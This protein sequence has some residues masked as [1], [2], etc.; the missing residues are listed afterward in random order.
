MNT[1]QI[2]QQEVICALATPSGVGAIAIIRVSGL[3]SIA[4][5]NS[6]FS[7]KNLENADTHTVHFG[8]IRS[9]DEIIDEVLVTVFKT[10]KS[11]TKED[12][13]EISCHGSDYIIGRS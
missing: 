7:G 3:G 6:I 9:A 13:V 5:V 11:F 4:L 10:P 1:M 8:T 2:H 12:S